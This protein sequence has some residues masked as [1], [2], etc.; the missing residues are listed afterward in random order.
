MD[1][2]SESNHAEKQSTENVKEFV[3]FLLDGLKDKRAKHI[4]MLRYFSDCGPKMTWKNIAKKVGVSSQTAINI[5][6][7]AKK[8]LKNKMKSKEIHDKV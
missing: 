4:Y 2:I 1:K 3:S 6:N 7:R 8:I 5:H